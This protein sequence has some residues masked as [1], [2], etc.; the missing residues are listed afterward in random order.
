MNL[1]ALT[2]TEKHSIMKKK[3]VG[4]NEIPPVITEKDK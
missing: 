1:A 2:A 4:P 3:M